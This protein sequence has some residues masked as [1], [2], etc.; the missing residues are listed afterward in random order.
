MKRPF[1]WMAW[2][3]IMALML[4]RVSLA[5]A[6]DDPAP[7]PAPDPQPEAV[8]KQAPADAAPAPAPAPDPDPNAKPAPAEGKRPG[9]AEVPDAK[10]APTLPTVPV[11]RS[12]SLGPNLVA[13][14]STKLPRD[15]QGIWVLD[16]MYKPVRTR[17]IDV[18]GKGRKNVYY[19][20]YRVINRTGKPRMFVPQFTLVTDTNKRYDDSV[21]PAA[22]PVIQAREDG[23]PLRGAVD[24]IGM[25]PDSPEDGDVDRAVY[26]VAVWTD[27]D[28]AADSFKIFVRGLSDGYQVLAPA[29]APAAD[30]NAPVPAKAAKPAARY[31]TLRL[32]FESPGDEFDRNEKEI[33]IAEP[34]YE[35][36]YW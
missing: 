1:R 24:I 28:P 35:W 11:K 16:F 18:P 12:A 20:W 30:G 10:L 21:I 2:A 13:V 36:V 14:D 3:L 5:Q 15:K 23:I 22:V 29:S 17:V 6:Q 7:A 19:L 33:H 27:V 31:K 34:P 8:K 4:G 32:D 9:P 26:G 25:I